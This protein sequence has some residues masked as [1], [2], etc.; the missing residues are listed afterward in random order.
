MVDWNERFGNEEYV[1]GTA[2][3]AW[4]AAQA[5]RIRS[6][7]RVLSL[8][9][10]EGRN[11]VWLAGQ[12]FAVDGVDGSSVGQEKA[13]ALA[14]SRGVAVRWTLA[15]LAHYEPDAEAF[16]AVVLIFLHLPPELRSRVHAKARAALAPG[17]VLII[18]A[19]APGQHAYASG[20]PR[21]PEL[22]YTAATLSDD[23]ADIAWDVLEETV[24]E[25]DEGGGHAGLGAVVRGVG[26]KGDRSAP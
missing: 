16:D 13:R 8:G 15:D 6:A 24:T 10:G 2:P 21:N 26:R 4:L 1:F 3:N 12:G 11:A 23:F 22:L 17:G 18:E 20:G 5:H 7:G 14:L 19:F 9:E 25:L